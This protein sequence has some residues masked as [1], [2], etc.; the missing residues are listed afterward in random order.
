MTARALVALALTLL[1]RS[2]A[3]CAVCL[4]SAFGNRSFNW[5][6][7]LFMLTPFAVAAGLGV[8]LAR[9]VLGSR[10]GA[11]APWTTDPAGEVNSC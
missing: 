4:D 5:A 10:R 11:D 7:V 6:F 8:A 2:A 1:P 3:A 9:R